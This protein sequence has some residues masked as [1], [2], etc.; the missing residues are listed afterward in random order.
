[1]ADDTALIGWLSD[2]DEPCPVCGYLLR[3]IAEPLCPECN[4][5]LELAVG[6]PDLRL[7]PWTTA[8]VFVS[9][10][11]GFDAAV[12]TM[13]TVPLVGM[14]VSGYWPVPIDFLAMYAAFWIAAAGLGAALLLLFRKRRSLQR[15]SA[16]AQWIVAGTTGLVLFVGQGVA[17]A[18]MVLL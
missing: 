2:T 5:G 12:G 7:A 8:V 15:H 1:M 6:S 3:G 17:G 10:A 11:L 13:L 16:R 9:M 18:A 14:I 4:A